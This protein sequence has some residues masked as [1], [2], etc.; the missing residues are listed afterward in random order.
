[1][2]IIGKN[3]DSAGSSATAPEPFDGGR[4]VFQSAVATNTAVKVVIWFSPRSHERYFIWHQ[5]NAGRARFL[6]VSDGKL[7]VFCR[8]DEDW[9]LR[10]NYEALVRADAIPKQ[11]QSGNSFYYDFLKA[12]IDRAIEMHET[13]GHGIDDL[14]LDALL[15]PHGL[16]TSLPGLKMLRLILDDIQLFAVRKQLVV[17]A[18]QQ[19]LAQAFTTILGGD[20]PERPPRQEQPADQQPANVVRFHLIGIGPLPLFLQPIPGAADNVDAADNVEVAG[21]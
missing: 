2:W 8:D 6:L 1:M 15:R 20:V 18:E 19:R 21:N 11:L 4:V 12:S 13:H 14:Y 10:T 9:N 3:C 5:H 7:Q 16:T 17:L